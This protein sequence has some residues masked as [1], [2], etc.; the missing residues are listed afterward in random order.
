MDRLGRAAVARPDAQAWTADITRTLLDI[1][2][3]AVRPGRARVC[4]A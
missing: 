1:P 3:E 2:A 4:P